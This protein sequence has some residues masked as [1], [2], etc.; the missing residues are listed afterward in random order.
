M[1]A[2]AHVHEDRQATPTAILR[3]AAA[4]GASQP[5]VQGGAATVETWGEIGGTLGTGRVF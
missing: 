5:G 1:H 2:V 3:H 4:R